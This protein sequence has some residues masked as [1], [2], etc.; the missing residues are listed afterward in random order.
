MFASL[1]LVLRY[2]GL[3]VAQSEWRHRFLLDGYLGHIYA[4]SHQD[5][6]II[7]LFQKTFLDYFDV[8]LNSTL[9][10]NVFEI[11]TASTTDGTASGTCSEATLA[12]HTLGPLLHSVLSH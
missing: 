3:R 2:G 11:K 8:L 6:L 10:F 5:R 4:I 12:H 1:D 9:E 7:N